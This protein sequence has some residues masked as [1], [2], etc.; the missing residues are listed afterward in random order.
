MTKL[1]DPAPR[2]DD[3]LCFLIHST[4]FAFNRAY[5]KPLEELGLTYPQYLAMIVLWA[6]NDLT[7]GAIGDRLRLDSGTLTPLLKRLE[8]QGMVTRRRSSTD[9][10]RVVIS[11]TESGRAL[12]S[13]AAEVMNCVSQAVDLPDGQIA[14]L[15]TQLKDLRLNLDRAGT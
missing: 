5:R 13:R 2:L 4:G 14:S 6:E 10:R 12:R 3:L 11:L 9:E 1:P 8:A 15:M 7:V